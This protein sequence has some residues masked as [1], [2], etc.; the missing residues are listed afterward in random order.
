MG[1]VFVFTTSSH[2][3]YIT[4]QFD[5]DFMFG[6]N[7][8]DF[9]KPVVSIGLWDTQGVGFNQYQVSSSGCSSGCSSWCNTSH[10]GVG[11]S[12]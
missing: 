3:L 11:C 12:R 5:C 7:V 1:Q 4:M 9:P 8:V 2:K 10:T 6:L